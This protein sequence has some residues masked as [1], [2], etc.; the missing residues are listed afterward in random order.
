[1]T[2]QHSHD[3]DV[4]G[5]GEAMVLLEPEH[6][7]DLATAPRLDVKVAGAELNACAA[8]AA[9]GGSSAFLTRLG[10][11]PLSE[12]VI[13]NA[14]SA[15]V[16]VLAERGEREQVGVFFKQ[17]SPGENR[18]VFYYRSTSAASRMSPS[19]LRLAAPI[20]AGAVLVSGL[21]AAISPGAA[22]VLLAVPRAAIGQR[23][24]V[25]ANLR[26]AL[27]HLDRSLRTIRALLPHTWILSLGVDEAPLLFGTDEPSAIAAAA[28]RAG[29]SEVVIKDGPRGAYW[30][31]DD[32][33]PHHIPPETVTA[34][35]TVGAGDAF[36]GS[37]VWARLNGHSRRAAATLASA[38]AAGVVAR[39]G[40]TEGL[41][42]P[43]ELPALLA[44]LSRAADDAA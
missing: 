10:D 41:P 14:R 37:Y 20:R 38:V 6:S 21:T 4:I 39:H 40:D 11:D 13:A 25:D 30:V 15:G 16:A 29:C 44:R 7:A 19:L 22:E 43:S 18:S 12:R 42:R 1:M 3:V 23:L 2:S 34:V 32:A 9:L 26:P 5:I 36:T 33:R 35:D 28:H 27:G 24:V 31:D 8:V 17:H